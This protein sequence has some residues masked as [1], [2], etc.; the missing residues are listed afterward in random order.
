[1]KKNT[2]GNKG[3]DE[4]FHRGESMVWLAPSYMKYEATIQE[5]VM[6]FMR[7]FFNLERVQQFKTR[8]QKHYANDADE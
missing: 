2:D 4:V 7:L 1:M 6:N 3:P 8:Y 5:G